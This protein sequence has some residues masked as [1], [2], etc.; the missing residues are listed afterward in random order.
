MGGFCRDCRV[1]EI[2]ESRGSER[3]GGIA[4]L[5]DGIT[6]RAME[7][8]GLIGCYETTLH[9]EFSLATRTANNHMWFR[10]FLVHEDT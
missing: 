9:S 7:F 3:S 8:G 10:R 4:E 2:V 6:P 5:E 1:G